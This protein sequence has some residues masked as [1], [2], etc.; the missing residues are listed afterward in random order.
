VDHARHVHDGRVSQQTDGAALPE[1]LIAPLRAA[2]GPSNVLT[3]ADLRATYETD[4]TRRFHGEAALVVR[5]GSVDEVAAVL[6]MC[7]EVGAAVVPQ[8]GNTGLVGGGVPRA[9][10]P[11]DQHGSP[12]PQVVLS[13]AR[14]REIEPVDEVAGELTVAAGVTLAA[15]QNHARR[16]G[17]DFGIDMGSRDSATVG[18][19]V[20]TNAGGVNVLRYGVMRQQLVG[21][22]G[23]LADGTIMR[24]L[25]GLVKDN[26]GYALGSLLAGSEGT[27]AVVSKV[28]LRLVPALPRKAV[29]LLAVDDAGQAAALAAQLRRRLPTIT[30]AELF[31]DD[32]MRLVLD[33]AGG[34]SPFPT[35]HP[36]YLLVESA[37]TSDPTDELVEAVDGLATQ[38]VVVASDE[39]GRH[40][41]WRLRENHTEA[42]NAAG[43]PH[44]LDVAVPI[45]QIGEFDVA[46]REAITR[47]DP[48]ARTFVYGHVGDGNLHVNV[49]G[50]DP[51]D[52]RVDDAVLAL[53]IRMGGAV[54][55]EHGIGV[56]KVR[57]LVPD[58][59]DPDVS[60]MR[61][62]KR[63]LDPGNVLNPGVLFATPPD[64][65]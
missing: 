17:W 38:D 63:S 29:A 31:D 32:G 33:H 24:R 7:G 11:R 16:A 47:V 48:G 56:A 23:V 65:G 55:A 44:K 35:A 8:G 3:D 40:R 13:T 45:G 34:E 46:V 43:V 50:P 19:M 57:W 52:E 5:P 22:E 61:A 53:A 12:R 10:A 36:R 49:L 51:D 42:V 59:G 1:Q 14:L 62:I 60:A 6:R 27:L 18:A 54:S 2:V 9:A 26:T 64:P 41:L 21:I 25:P 20:A 28:R 58:R 37:A 39:G 4:W 15:L 30:A